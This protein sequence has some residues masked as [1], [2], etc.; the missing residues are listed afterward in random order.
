MGRQPLGW[1]NR[2][3][4]GRI[5]LIGPFIGCLLLQ[6]GT[7]HAGL[8]WGTLAIFGLMAISDFLDG[9]LARRLQQESSL[10][11]VLDPLADKLLITSSVLVLWLLG[12]RTSEG[13]APAQT[14]H[15][16]GWVVGIALGKD[17]VVLGGNFLAK[18]GSIDVRM[19]ARPMGKWCTTAQLLMVLAMLLWPTWPDR[20]ADFVL[21]LW[22]AA[23]FL[24]IV[25]GGDYAVL[26]VQALRAKSRRSEVV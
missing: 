15:L 18:L 7:G 12:V 11:R 22:W 8:R 2:I 16:P 26:G 23:S 21:F 25:A 13:V 6:A 17:L 3:T 5:C 10:G 4:I 20:S 24:A 9:Y 14:L 1:P 19:Q